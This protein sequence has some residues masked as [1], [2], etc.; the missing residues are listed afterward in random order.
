MTNE[1]P[2]PVARAAS[3]ETE[4]PTAINPT[5]GSE[6][7]GPSDLPTPSNEPVAALTAVIQQLLG[8][9]NRLETRIEQLEATPARARNAVAS[10]A[11]EVDAPPLR[12]TREGCSRLLQ[13]PLKGFRRRSH[14][15]SKQQRSRRQGGRCRSLDTRIEAELI[16]VILAAAIRAAATP[17]TGGAVTTQGVMTDKSGGAGTDDV[18]R[19]RIHDDTTGGK[20]PKT[21][22]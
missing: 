18:M 7:R 1:E 13:R 6:G 4:R 20:T 9:M 3:A 19:S 21:W 17:V 14:A 22:N 15:Q 11:S 8:T 12:P 10:A 5:Q 2:V 16:E